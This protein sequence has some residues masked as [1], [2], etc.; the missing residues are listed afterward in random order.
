MFFIKHIDLVLENYDV[1]TIDGKHIGYFAL[2][3]IKKTASVMGCNSFNVY[4]TAEE[5]FLE[6]SADGN[7][8]HDELGLKDYTTTV[9]E[10]LMRYPDITS[11]HIY[12]DDGE[13]SYFTNWNGDEMN[14]NQASQI[15]VNGCLYLV[16]SEKTTASK[17]FSDSLQSESDKYE[18]GFNG[19][20]RDEWGG[21]KP[22]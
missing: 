2:E 1:I 13:Y 17:F 15:G 5:V 11:V 3:D 12:G 19:W 10:R 4:E 20:M 14:K 18:Y 7:T 16:I 9:F 8:K 21:D 22:G 6:I